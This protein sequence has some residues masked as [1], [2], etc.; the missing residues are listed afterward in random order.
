[1]RHVI[2]PGDILATEYFDSDGTYIGRDVYKKGETP[3][4]RPGYVDIT[5][6]LTIAELNRLSQ[7]QREALFHA[8]NRH[9][10]DEIPDLLPQQMTAIRA[11]LERFDT[12]DC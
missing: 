8:A 5:D 12:I 10:N 11:E 6:Q 9:G 2:Q 3:R 1:M 7:E 4:P